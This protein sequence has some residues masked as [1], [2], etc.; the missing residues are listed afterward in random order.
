MEELPYISIAMPIFERNR[1]TPLILSNL[2]K[3]DY[4]K[5][6]LEFV[7]DDDGI[8][9]KFVNNQKE[10]SELEGVLYP[11]EV[12]YKFY[13]EKRSIGKK[14]NNLVKLAKHKLIA[15]MD[16]DDLYMSSYLKHS[17]EVMKKSKSGLVCSNQ[18]IF[19]Y[20]KH[21]WRATG[22]QCKHK[23]LGHE[24][25]MLFTKKYFKA[26]GGFENSS[27][28]EG[29]NFIKGMKDNAIAMTEIHLCMCCICHDNNTVSKDMFL[30]H[31][32]IKINLDPY[33]RHIISQCLG[34]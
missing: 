8:E 13:K 22:I 32:D 29:V 1:F 23:Y 28:G 6:K 18:M 19:L 3:L 26:M 2:T 17:L 21:N 7:I 10:L 11:I 12:N 30:E 14:R 5:D 31:Q 4:P 9:E 15:F 16:S 33:D 20:P 24:A 25:T 27:R 34:I